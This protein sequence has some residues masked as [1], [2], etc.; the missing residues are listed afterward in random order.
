MQSWG[1]LARRS[2]A[3]R[4]LDKSNEVSTETYSVGRHVVDMLN[5]KADEHQRKQADEWLPIFLTELRHKLNSPC[6]SL[7]FHDV[8]SSSSSSVFHFL[9]PSWRR[10]SLRCHLPDVFM[11]ATS[12]LLDGAPNGCL[13]TSLS[14]THRPSASAYHR[15][16][17]SPHCFSSST[18]PPHVRGTIYRTPEVRR[19]HHS[20]WFDPRITTSPHTET[21]DVRLCALWVVFMLLHHWHLYYQLKV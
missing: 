14:S 12:F 11:G 21:L 13:S 8:S 17:F 7:A 19:W 1:W 3:K 2:Q 5:K 6:N 4:W 15:D 16:V 9:R 20:H 18:L 10:S